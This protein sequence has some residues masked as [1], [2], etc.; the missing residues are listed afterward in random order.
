[1]LLFRP[2]FLIKL[3]TCHISKS[4]LIKAVI[5]HKIPFV[6]CHKYARKKRSYM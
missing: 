2:A 6:D 1:M 3:G 5:R 4:P